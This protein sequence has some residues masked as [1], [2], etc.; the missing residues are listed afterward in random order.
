MTMKMSFKR[1]FWGFVLGTVFNMT[2]FI[3]LVFS[4]GV[5]APSIRT[6]I[7]LLA[8]PTGNAFVTWLIAMVIYFPALVIA[9]FG[10][11]TP[12]PL[13]NAPREGGVRY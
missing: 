7:A 9:S 13:R 11:K 4:N 12:P 10:R 8:F 5:P 1:V 2:F 6:P 3:W